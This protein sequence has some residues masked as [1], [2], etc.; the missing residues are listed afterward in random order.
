MDR[1]RFGSSS[2]SLRSSSSQRCFRVFFA[3]GGTDGDEAWTALRGD[4]ER[5]E[6]GGDMYVEAS[7]WVL[8]VQIAGLLRFRRR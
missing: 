4:V 8:D 7:V 5:C 6:R 2:I 3:G 1:D